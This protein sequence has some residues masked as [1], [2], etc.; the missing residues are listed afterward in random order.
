VLNTYEC[1]SVYMKT[2]CIDVYISVYYAYV[3]S[4]KPV[5]VC[6]ARSP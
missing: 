4:Y 6:T 3:C 5:Y 1:V 2:V